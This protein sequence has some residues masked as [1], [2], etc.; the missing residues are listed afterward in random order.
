MGKFINCLVTTDKMKEWAT[1]LNIKPIEVNML[2]SN[3]VDTNGTNPTFEDIKALKEEP[4]VLKVNPTT[5]MARLN[6]QMSPAEINTRTSMIARDFSGVINDALSNEI[7][8]LENQLNDPSVKN[9]ERIKEN[10][11]IL[12]DPIKGRRKVLNEVLTLKGAIDE[13]RESYQ[14]YAESSVEDLNY[15]SEGNGQHYKEAYNKIIDNFDALIKEAMPIIENTENFRAV[16][17]TQESNADG[18]YI[19]DSQSDSDREENING[20]DENGNRVNGSEGWSFNIR[21]VDPASSIRNETRKI[22]SNIREVDAN[23]NMLTDDLGQPRYIREDSAHATLLAE[24]AKSVISP[25]DFSVVTG[26]DENGENVYSLPALDKLIEKYPWV[27]QIKDKLLYNPTLISIFYNDFRKDFIPQVMQKEGKTIN[28]NQDLITSSAL[29]D[30]LSNYTYSIP[31]T[32]T[33]I[34]GTDIEKSKNN[35]RIVRNNI[36]RIK[37]RIVSMG[38][39]VD[40]TAFKDSLNALKSIG[41]NFNESHLNYLLKQEDGVSSLLN[42]LDRVSNI[43]DMAES[44]TLEADFLPI[45]DQEDFSAIASA[46]GSVSPRDN[47]MSYRQNGNTYQSYSAPNYSEVMFKRLTDTNDQ[48]RTEYINSEFKQYPWFYNQ[49]LEEWRNE[50][51]RLLEEDPNVRLNCSLCDMKNIDGKEYKDWTKKMIK[52]EFLKKFYSL[53]ESTSSRTQYGW[54]NFPIFSD[55]EVAKFIKMPRYGYKYKE[56]ITPLLENVVRQELSRIKNVLQRNAKGISV[57]QN[58]DS[59][60]R[61]FCFFP[62]LNGIQFTEEQLPEIINNIMDARFEDYLNDT[63]LNNDDINMLINSGF[64]KDTKGV[65]AKMENY[66]WNQ[67]FATSQI[68]ELTTTDL[69][70]YKNDNG[71]DF[72]KRYK[73]V[74]A[75]GIKLNTNSKYGKEKENTIY[76]H[77]LIN[78]SSYY[79]N[80]KEGLNEAVKDKR[81]SKAD[82]DVILNKFKN[83]NATDAQAFRTLDSYRSVMD[84]LGSWTPEMEQTFERF[85]AGNWDM[86]DFYTIWQTI[87]PFLYTQVSTD[88]GLGN[89]IKVPHQNKNSEFLLLSSYQLFSNLLGKSDKMRALNDFMIHN[90]IDVAQYESAVK[91][92]AQS[93]LDINYS[94]EK[95][96]QALQDR[97]ITIDNINYLLEDN[98][99]DIDS[100]K[101]DLDN[102]LN[103]GTI[104]QDEY[105]NII[106][107]LEPSYDEVTDI[108]EREALTNETNPTDVLTDVDGNTYNSSV[109]HQLPYSDY[110]VAQANPE[111]LLDT[112]SVF[113]SQFRNLITSDLDE[114]AQI[115]VNGR[116][117]SGRDNIIKEYQSLIVENL[118]EDYSKLLNTFG[119]IESLQKKMLQIVNGNPKFGRDMIDALQIV[120]YNGT[121][122]FNVPL[123][124]PNTTLKIQEVINSM[125]KN[126]ITKQSIK[127]GSCVL[128]SD[129]GYTNELSVVRDDKGNIQYAEAYVPAYTK[130]FYSPFLKDVVVDGN[131][132]GKEIDID[133]IKKEDARLLDIIGYRIPTEG[134]YS[135]MPIVIKGFLPQQNGSSIMMPAEL[136]T[137]AGSDFDVDKLFLM[138]PEME[139]KDGIFKKV[140]YDETK[141]A[142]ENSREQRNNKII[143]IARSILQTKAASE[144][145]N[146]PGTFDGIKKEAYKVE[147]LTDEILLA[148]Y[149]N[150]T[151]GPE[152]QLS[153]SDFDKIY[154]KLS[155]E[156]LDTLKGFI[157]AKKER[158]SPITPQNFAYYHNQNMTGAA[159]IGMYAN[160]TT[161]QAKFQLSKLS[162]KPEYTF[163]IN[164]RR[165]SSLHDVYTNINGVRTKIS[166]LCAQFSAASVDNV[167]EPVLDKLLQSGNTASITGCML[168]SG[169]S[170]EEITLLFNS[171]VIKS[172]L[173]SH[174]NNAY[175]IEKYIDTLIDSYEAKY[176]DFEYSTDESISSKDIIKSTVFK[177]LNVQDMETDAIALKAALI[178]SNI[179]K[180]SKDLSALTQVSRADSPNGAIGRNVALAISQVMNIK[181]LN[182]S[183]NLKS[184]TLS[185]IENILNMNVAPIGSSIDE[186][187]EN[188]NKSQMPLLQ[189][190][191][192][193]GIESGINI[194][195]KYLTQL[196]DYSSYMVNSLFSN[197]SYSRA[198]TPEILNKFYSDMITFGLSNTKLF[199]NDGKRTYAQK[200]DYYLYDFPMKAM[201]VIKDNPDILALGAMKRITIKDGKL[202]F[203]NS[204]RLNSLSSEMFMSDFN[205]LLYMDNPKAQK[206]AIDLFMYSY[207]LNG[208]N[209][210]P[211]S[212]GKFFSAQFL[213]SFPEFMSSLRDMA[214]TMGENTYWD[215]F[216]PL[217]YMNNYQNYNLVPIAKNHKT[218]TDSNGGVRI[219]VPKQDA[220]NRNQGLYPYMTSNGKLFALDTSKEFSDLIEYSEVN[221]PKTIGIPYYDAQSPLADSGNYVGKYF[222]GKK[223]SIKQTDAVTNTADV[224]QDVM[225]FINEFDNS[226]YENNDS[227]V[228]FDRL[229]LS[230]YD[231]E[232]SLED[233][234]DYNAEEGFNE[235][236][237]KPCNL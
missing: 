60:G 166:R 188:I 88:D 123:N 157:K 180:I 35:G 97:K 75:S 65:I 158:K 102:K 46:I 80:I 110:M 7:S 48:A 219:A 149:L 140:D 153:D 177:T 160:N 224:D 117:I 122:V 43:A 63:P 204:A 100:L 55:S 108:L 76:L 127:G 83:V 167:K 53:P 208:F 199:G 24:L 9:K 38:M 73:E 176:G 201:S 93:I 216:M 143:D 202:V 179:Y 139:N 50:W 112:E 20:D 211:N 104:N 232:A 86:S 217:F 36:T 101:D 162:I 85:K 212:Y 236:D 168:R 190:F 113:G 94:P 172:Y 214:S 107:Y 6:N 136:T 222:N 54:Y 154:K 161:A 95:I 49:K 144:D 99:N 206:L 17:D 81:I 196:S 16:I 200:R 70:F 184:F 116:T 231:I 234:Q 58:Y 51:L 11:L 79:D 135:M 30:V 115:T 163:V 164:G 41:F 237:I 27:S 175:G 92:G 40:N 189:S 218:I 72:Q 171:P 31:L 187:R 181:N 14:A 106:N 57:I 124:N 197:A 193:L 233:T 119:S 133:K 87:K 39:R 125:F 165:I 194:S 105:N 145:I 114:D 26:V 78:T 118:L 28:L 138:I 132:V 129:V 37:R 82:A 185:G 227:E 62:E 32:D 74:Y 229:D 121:K 69:A 191:Y 225:D 4:S 147:I 90:N 18:G 98:V 131:V 21:G 198:I 103:N 3:Y 142:S 23:G 12:K 209:Y 207:Y 203:S 25:N 159:L 96:K 56:T 109:V 137:I 22:L 235:N 148:E 44:S 186:I 47:V 89:K 111:H 52:L 178:F 71:V 13:L 45:T 210:G 150:S 59:T 141:S 84:M 226:L 213:N 221:I 10:L 146:N 192:S 130:S 228:D 91:C 8:R 77:D 61:E 215:K 128:V 64:A 230:G 5:S 169:M 67:T 170:I 1:K 66:F 120:D 33:P 42:I 29:D 152:A 126:A 173:E 183:L 174:D 134:K 195:A 156:S 182:N 34:Y 155:E 205:S 68:I 223:D 15:I 19:D 2:Y 220:A 151:I